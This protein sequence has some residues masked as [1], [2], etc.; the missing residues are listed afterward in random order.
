M[1]N[2]KEWRDMKEHDFPRLDKLTIK[3]CPQMRVLC[4]LPNFC[5]LEYLKINCC[6]KLPG[7]SQGFLPESIKTVVVESC[8]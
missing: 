2:R 8:P 7:F 1:V 6:P 4:R 3:D 5:S